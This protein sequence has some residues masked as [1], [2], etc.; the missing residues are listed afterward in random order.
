[1]GNPI[2]KYYDLER[3]AEAARNGTHRNLVGGFWDELGL[4]QFDFAKNRGLSPDHYVL[5]IGC[6]C[7]RGGVHFVHY[8]TPGHYYGIDLSQDLLDVGYDVELSRLKLQTKL[9]RK[10]LACDAEFDAGQFGVTFDIVIAVSLFTHLPFEH[11]RL[12]LTKLANVVR[13]GGI[14]YATIF[15]CP[16]DHD[17]LQPLEHSPGSMISHSSRDPYHYRTEDVSRLV[18]GLP[19]RVDFIG[20]WHHPRDQSMIM[21]TRTGS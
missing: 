16:H 5:D 18:A 14:I 12:C 10:N 13:Q 4:L 7:L 1:M 3:S 9:P 19:W 17:W 6:G 15:H 20:D 21:F 11:V 8:L 2:N